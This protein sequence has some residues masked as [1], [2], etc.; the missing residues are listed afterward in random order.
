M[1]DHIHFL[2]KCPELGAV[3]HIAA[4]EMDIGSERLRV[5]RGKIVEPT[6]LMALTG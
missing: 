4:G 1:I 2:E 5:A 6:N 3:A